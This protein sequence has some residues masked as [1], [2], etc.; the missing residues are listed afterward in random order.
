MKEDI[1]QNEYDILAEINK[2]TEYF[3]DILETMPNLKLNKFD[4][5]FLINTYKETINN[6]VNTAL[7]TKQKYDFCDKNNIETNIELLQNINKLDEKQIALTIKYIN[8]LLKK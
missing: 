6:I 2:N 8:N 7:L 4:R 1:I 5:R 3:I